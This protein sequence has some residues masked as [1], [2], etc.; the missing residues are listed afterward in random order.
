MA[1]CIALHVASTSRTQFFDANYSNIVNRAC[2]EIHQIQTGREINGA[3]AEPFVS[4][5]SLFVR[6]LNERML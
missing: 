5:R 3:N 4:R 6:D 1:T 2:I